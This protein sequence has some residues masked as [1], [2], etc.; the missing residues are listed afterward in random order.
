[1]FKKYLPS[2]S[3]KE[4]LLIGGESV[5]DQ[6]GKLREGVDVVTG[7]PGKFDDFVSTEKMSLDQVRFFILDEAVSKDT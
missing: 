7:T 3:I 2:P 5:R 6:I 1:M 4:V